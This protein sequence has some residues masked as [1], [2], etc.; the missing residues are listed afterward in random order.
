MRALVVEQWTVIT[1]QERRIAEADERIAMQDERIAE[2]E[3]RLG[4]DSS[5]RPSSSD[6]RYCRP[7][8][9]SSRRASG[10]K[11]GKQPGAPGSTMGLVKDPD[12]VITLDP[13]CC[14]GVEWTCP[15]RRCVG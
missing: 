6:S 4:R 3:W 7:P 15:V 14:G 9:R 1:A 13:G 5:N 10:R 12:D 11:P 2:L 8:P